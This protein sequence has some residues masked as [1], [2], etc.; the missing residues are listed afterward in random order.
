MVHGTSEL[1]KLIFLDFYEFN[2][3]GFRLRM[4]AKFLKYRNIV[5]KVLEVYKY[6]NQKN[7]DI[8]KNINL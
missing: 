5:N 4:L 3:Y 8:V 2:G 7:D 1:T 6:R